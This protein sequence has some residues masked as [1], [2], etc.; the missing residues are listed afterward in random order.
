M[1]IL[2]ANPEDRREL[3]RLH[4]I[5]RMTVE[6][7]AVQQYSTQW[8]KS[9]DTRRQVEALARVTTKIQER[10]Q[11]EAEKRHFD[12]Q[13]EMVREGF[14]RPGT[15]VLGSS[16]IYNPLAMQRKTAEWQRELDNRVARDKTLRDIE[17]K[18]KNQVGRLTGGNKNFVSI[19]A[20]DVNDPRRGGK[21]SQD[22]DLLTG[23]GG[24]SSVK[25]SEGNDNLTP[26]RVPS[27]PQMTKAEAK[28]Y[29]SSMR[30]RDQYAEKMRK[31]RAQK[32][33]LERYNKK[34][35]AAYHKRKAAERA[36]RIAAAKK[37]REEEQR[38][39]ELLKKQKDIETGYAAGAALSNVGGLTGNQHVANM[40]SVFTG[41]TQIKAG[42]K[43]GGAGTIIR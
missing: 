6:D 5:E 24:S 28:A 40:G 18:A 31:Y 15:V 12:I 38:K 13:Q 27:K 36:A 20:R 42:D 17:R 8:Q 29:T 43:L 9:V 3:M 25:G 30:V 11:M 23:G 14:S 32:R 22:N 10:A 16:G 2:K 1:E 7:K 35:L 26:V 4:H 39:A 41:A 33:A 19:N 34:R 37:K 21:P